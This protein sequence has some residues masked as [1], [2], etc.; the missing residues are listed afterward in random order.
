MPAST[1]QFPKR[2]AIP[3]PRSALAAATPH[4]AS[5]ASPPSLITMP[6]QTSFWG[7]YEHGDCVTAEE[8][9]AK[10]CNN[11]EILISDSEVI[12]WATDHGV[13]E[14]AYLNQ[15]L[16]W[17]QNDGFL[18]IGRLYD[19]GP[20]L[21]VNWTDSTILQ[22]AIATG[23]VK[24][25]VA[26]DQLLTAWDSAGGNSSGGKTW[27]GTGFQSDSNED[28][29]VSLCGYGTLDWLAQQLGVQVP[30][31]VDGTKQ[32]YALFTW[33]SIGII[34]EPS[35]LAITHEA[36]LRQPT[37][38]SLRVAAI[39]A[40]SWG[41]NRLDIFGLGTENQMYHKAWDGTAWLPSPTGW[42][43]LGGVF[44]SPPAVVSWGA[45][46]LDIF[47]LGT[48]NQMYQKTWN[49]TAWL[50]SP[51]GWQPLGGVFDS[52]PAVVSWGANRLDI[53]GL[54]TDNQ[55]YHKAWDGTAWLPSPT[56][57]EALGGVFDS[58]PAVVSWGANRLDIFGL[59][60]DN[61]MYQKT[62]NG[63]AWLPSP[64]GWQP[65]GGVFDPL[66]A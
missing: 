10:A 34:D 2:G 50:P 27:F 55:M 9:F 48:D 58:A 42:E 43:A 54:G 32:G 38:I 17:M 53:F 5:A 4:V 45:N 56:G 51:T 66:L 62:W 40:T 8:A 23:P 25:G 30:V 52:P 57:W 21:S 7:N 31:G 24:I 28:H 14:G 44:D 20:Y 3:S 46:R 26:G 6:K 37:T 16:Q 41:A 35:M 65:L 61:Q 33:D 29:C 47:G 64:T 59:G 39:A 15:V 18:Q 22:S 60:T 13:L 63:T 1:L 49:G 11:P 19:D 36:W 12:T